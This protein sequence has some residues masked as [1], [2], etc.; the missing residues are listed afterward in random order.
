M[1]PKMLVLSKYYAN[2]CDFNQH[3]RALVE[4]CA[5]SM[6]LFALFN[7]SLY[8]RYCISYVRC[9]Y[10]GRGG[11]P[12]CRRP[13]ALS[14]GLCPRCRVQHVADVNVSG[15]YIYSRTHCGSSQ[16]SFCVCACAV[17]QPLTSQLHSWP[18]SSSET[19]LTVPD[20]VRPS[21]TTSPR[22]SATSTSGPGR[23]CRTHPRSTAG[24]YAV[25]GGAC[26]G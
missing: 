24:E 10:C 1:L 12:H 23:S 21:Q 13:T 4:L 19:S 16:L 25:S 8:S 20:P 5:S 22:W 11:A 15:G 7:N 9:S 14:A 18:P 3:L 2:F 6:D 26:I 17:S